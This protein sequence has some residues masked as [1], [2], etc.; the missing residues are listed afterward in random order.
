MS[1]LD[2]IDL[3]TLQRAFDASGPVT[4][5]EDD[6]IAPWV[7]RKPIRGPKPPLW[8]DLPESE[9]ELPEDFRAILSAITKHWLEIGIKYAMES[10]HCETRRQAIAYL[11][12]EKLHARA[13]ALENRANQFLWIAHPEEKS[14]FA[15]ATST[16]TSHA[17]AIYVFCKSDPSKLVECISRGGEFGLY[18]ADKE[19][20]LSA[21]LFGKK[22]FAGSEAYC[23]GRWKQGGIVVGPGVLPEPGKDR[24]GARTVIEA[25]KPIGQSEEWYKHWLP[26]ADEYLVLITP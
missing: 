10:C 3:D 16:P 15:Y 18:V 26:K 6:Q 22:S 1:R 23:I 4:R 21:K 25:H 7:G 14:N 13:E 17:V 20:V 19:L 24:F 2:K 11:A 8:R 12:Y 5:R 9:R